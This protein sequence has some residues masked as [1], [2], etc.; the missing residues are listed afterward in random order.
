M[1]TELCRDVGVDRSGES[2][3][4]LR[5]CFSTWAQ[6]TGDN[7]AVSLIM[8]HEVEA[9]R[10]GYRHSF[11]AARLLAVSDYVR[12]KIFGRGQKRRAAQ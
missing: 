4:T 3:Y 2:F 11:P 12:E 5:H 1:F 7:D 9:I 8:G 6:E 10:T